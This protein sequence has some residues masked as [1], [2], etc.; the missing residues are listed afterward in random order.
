MPLGR[1]AIRTSMR[2]RNFS[3]FYTPITLRP[4]QLSDKDLDTVPASLFPS[5]ARKRRPPSHTALAGFL[6]PRIL[7]GCLLW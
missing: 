7:D 4:L 2:T 6:C 5:T 1:H 3:G